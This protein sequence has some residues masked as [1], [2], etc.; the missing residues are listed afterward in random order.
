[1]IHISVFIIRLPR[2]MWC[3]MMTH[4]HERLIVIPVFHPFDTFVGNDICHIP[5]MN[6]F[7]AHFNHFW[8]MV[9]SLAWQYIPI[10]KP[11][12]IIH[13]SVSQMPL[14]DDRC[15][16]TIFLQYFWHRLLP[17]VKSITQCSYTIKMIILPGQNGGTTRS[18]NRVRTITIMKDHTL[19]SNPV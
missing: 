5:L 16:I 1:M 11:S 15:L 18:S 6:V 19:I 9:I 12:R 7:F 3:L 4:Q 2:S 8:M 13:T 17:A 10:I 14:A